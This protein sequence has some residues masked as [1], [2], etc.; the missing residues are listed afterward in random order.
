MQIVRYTSDQKPVWDAFVRASRNATFLHLRDYMDYHAHRFADCSLMFYREGKLVALLPAN[1]EASSS[2][3]YSHQGLTYGGLL[4]CDGLTSIRVLDI[5]EQMIRWMRTEL[6]ALR[7]VYKPIPHVYAHCPSGEDL[8]ALFRLGASL[9]TRSIASVIEM[10]HRIPF[11]KDRRSAL[12]RAAAQD[13]RVQESND[14]ASFW[15]ILQHLLCTKHQAVPVHTLDEMLH[16]LCKFPEN[17]HLYAAY[18]PDGRML[19]GTIIYE[20]PHLA[21]SQY[22]AS[23][24]EGRQV[25]AVDALYSWLINERYAHKRYVDLGTSV[26]QGGRV[27]NEGLIRQKEAFGARAVMYDSYLM[28]FL[29]KIDF[30]DKDYEQR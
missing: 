7:F 5:F 24:S 26:E 10:A 27:L 2:T 11:R 22:I 25:G 30:S 17:I 15:E 28:D 21:H 1:W 23:T 18:H 3:L 4:M 6:G 16:L 14:F 19:A 9:H 29:D 20:M 12:K 13:L 8:Y